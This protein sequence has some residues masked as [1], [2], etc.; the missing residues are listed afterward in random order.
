MVVRVLPSFDPAYK[1]STSHIAISGIIMKAQ[2]PSAAAF[3]GDSD[4][5]PSHFKLSDLAVLAR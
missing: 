5:L 4:P 3:P 1:L 2:I